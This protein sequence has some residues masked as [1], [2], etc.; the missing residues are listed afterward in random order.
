METITLFTVGYGAWSTKVRWSRLTDV[1]RRHQ[2]DVLCD[3]R[4]SPC[5][6]ALDPEHPYGARPWHLQA[7][8]QG[9]APALA[10]EGI[11]Y[12]WLVE[13]GNPQ[14]RDRDMTVLREHLADNDAGWPV[15]RG[16][17][18]LIHLAVN[19]GRRCCLL[20]ACEHY[21]GCHRSLVAAAFVKGV[22][23]RNVAVVDLA[24]SKEVSR[25][26]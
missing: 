23:P 7:S 12:R 26:Q 22:A 11:E 8:G 14:K 3:I 5:A 24:P 17:Q 19:E 9:I 25:N 4:H 18:Q 16:L 2:I 13:L 10:R 1:L 15:H 20:C 6:S 21:E